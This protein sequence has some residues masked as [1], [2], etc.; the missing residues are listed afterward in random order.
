MARPP[1][2]IEVGG[3]A[4]ARRRFVALSET[5]CRVADP[6]RLIRWIYRVEEL[7]DLRKLTPEELAERRRKRTKPAL[8]TPKRWLIEAAAEE[9]PASDLVK[10]AAYSLNHWTALTAFSTTA[11]SRPTTTCASSSSATSRTAGRISSSQART[12]LRRTPRCST[13]LRAPAHAPACRRC[14]T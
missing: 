7:P 14:R 12:T 1:L 10:A 11:A 5:D 8:D 3:W 6:L 13:A 4:Q 2:A 9:P